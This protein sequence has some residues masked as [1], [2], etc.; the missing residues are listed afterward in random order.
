MKSMGETLEDAR[1]RFFAESGFPPDGGYDD[2]WAH[3]QFGPVP[4]SVP[5]PPM[6]AEALRV[7]DLHHPLTG[8]RADWRGEA[9]ISAWEL[10][11]GGGGR[12]VYAWF[13]ALFGLF[14]GLLGAPRATWRA[15]VAGRSADNLYRDS[16][17]R[18]RLPH[19]VDA[20]R[21]ELGI[22]RSGRARPRD[23]LAFLG[24]SAL[25]CS[26][27]IVFGLGVPLLLLAALTRRVGRGVRCLARCPL[28]AAGMS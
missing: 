11:S 9:E 18:R 1:R 19:S 21:R 13:I 14:T 8:Y 15:F 22:G 16:A 17:P 28:H 3:A 2:A 10:G 6:R 7:H 5:N 25:A 26:L 27:A 24:W 20:M 23:G 12:Y 4:Y